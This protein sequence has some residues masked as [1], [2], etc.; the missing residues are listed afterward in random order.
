MEWLQTRT[1]P[2]IP[3]S[4]SN[5]YWYKLCRSYRRSCIATSILNWFISS[6]LISGVGPCCT[7]SF[8]FNSAFERSEQRAF[9]PWRSPSFSKLK[10]QCGTLPRNSA[11]PYCACD[12]WLSKARSEYSLVGLIVRHCSRDRPYSYHIWTF[13]RARR[14]ESPTTA[15]ETLESGVSGVAIG[16]TAPP[17]TCGR[18]QRFI[19]ENLRELC[20]SGIG[21]EWRWQCT[22]SGTRAIG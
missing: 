22:D 11:Q 12:V 4:C 8:W 10:L 15:T 19:A 7:S 18:Q 3:R 6:A 13:Y 1:T 5:F 2:P 14:A 17:G 9:C 21:L 16:S 20:S